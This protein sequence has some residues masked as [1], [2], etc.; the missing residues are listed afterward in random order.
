MLS[1]KHGLKPCSR[2]PIPLLRCLFVISRSAAA[3]LRRAERVP[4]VQSQDLTDD[5]LYE[6]VSLIQRNG[7]PTWKAKPEMIGLGRKLQ[8]TCM[9]SIRKHRISHL[10]TVLIYSSALI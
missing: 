7:K 10:F 5:T 1:C 9:D 4:R 2:V 8:Q 3:G 6:P